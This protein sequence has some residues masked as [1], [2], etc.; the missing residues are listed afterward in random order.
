MRGAQALLAL[1]ALAAAAGCGAVPCA[2][3]R[4]ASPPP[5]GRTPGRLCVED[6]GGADVWLD[7]VFVGT[8]PLSEPVAAEP[9]TH[10]V[11]VTM[12]GHEPRSEEV[13]LR[14]GE[15]LTLAVDLDMTT[16]RKASWAV[17]GA[18]AG[19]ITTGIVLGALAV[20][21]Q[22]RGKDLLDDADGEDLDA[23]GQAELDAALSAEDRFRIGSG[24][25]GGVGL[26]LVTVGVFLFAF[27]DPE[28][29]K[30]RTR[31]EV[32]LGPGGASARLRF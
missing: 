14:G 16:Q 31:P 15:T 4:A 11:T 5:P 12:S 26:G 25:A 29:P 8:A 32:R 1:A 30:R 27:D 7:G 13:R 21:E 28:L 23:A 22:R 18:G 24:V 17:L 9:G 10:D 2:A 20:V 3:T 6:P 19:G